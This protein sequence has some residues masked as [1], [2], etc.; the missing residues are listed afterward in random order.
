[1]TKPSP[2]TRSDYE[3]ICGALSRE[4]QELEVKAGITEKADDA[5]KPSWGNIDSDTPYLSEKWKAE[6]EAEF[7]FERD[8]VRREIRSLYFAVPDLDL[9]KQLIEKAR[10]LTDNERYMFMTDVGAAEA[11][12]RQAKATGKNWYLWASL[13]AIGFVALG[14]SLFQ[15][16]GALVGALVAYF[17]G[18]YAENDAKERRDL[19]VKQG[20]DHL[21]EVRSINQEILNRDYTFTKY[22]AK[23][24]EPDKE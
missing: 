7:Q 17:S 14:W 3:Q 1:M 15:L 22:E 10:E 13:G 2:K 20:E 4:L 21:K 12:L 18:R 6:E 24:G 19:S 8:Y 11:E 5:R 23:N 16:P 9:R